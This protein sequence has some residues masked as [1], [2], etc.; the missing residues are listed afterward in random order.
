MT[1]ALA[2]RAAAALDAD[3]RP[4]CDSRSALGRPAGDPRAVRRRRARRPGRRHERAGAL[5]GDEISLEHELLVGQQHDVARAAEIAR[6]LAR[7]RQAGVERQR[8]VLDHRAQRAGDLRVARALAVERQQ[9][10]GPG[11]LAPL[12]CSE[13]V[14][15]AGPEL[16]ALTVIATPCMALPPRARAPSTPSSSAA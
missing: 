3:V 9:H 4:R 16:T 15:F 2:R 7:R 1:I 12:K 13:L 6:E 8:A 14:L 5:P 10:V 11:E